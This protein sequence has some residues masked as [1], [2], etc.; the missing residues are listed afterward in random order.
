MKSVMATKMT[1]ISQI[2]ILYISKWPF[3][4]KIRNQNHFSKKDRFLNHNDRY[5]R[6][7][8]VIIK[9]TDISQNKR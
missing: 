2:V 3:I 7:R 1:V 8:G 6:K 4:Q 5:H 9:M